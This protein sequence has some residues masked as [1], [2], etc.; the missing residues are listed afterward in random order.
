MAAGVTLGATLCA[1]ASMESDRDLRD[2]ARAMAKEDVNVEGPT[3]E[4]AAPGR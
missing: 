1:T 3:L 2:N 4:A